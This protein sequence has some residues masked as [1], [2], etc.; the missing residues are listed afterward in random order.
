MLTSVYKLVHALEAGVVAWLA[1]PVVR[2]ELEN[3]AAAGAVHCVLDG[4]VAAAELQVVFVVL[5]HLWPV[6][7]VVHTEK[8]NTPP[9]WNREW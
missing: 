3:E 4:R 6:D 5:V 7:G 2:V 9:A 8:V 1:P